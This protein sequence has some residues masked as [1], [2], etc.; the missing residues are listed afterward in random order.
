KRERIAEREA[1]R[2]ILLTPTV[3]GIVSRQLHE[4]RWTRRVIGHDGHSAQ[5]RGSLG[6]I[7]LRKDVCG[8]AVPELDLDRWQAR[9]VQGS[10]ADRR[11]PANES[12]KLARESRKLDWR[13]CLVGQRRPPG[14]QIR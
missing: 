5:D 8:H 13:G 11:R 3:P 7:R 12:P 4:R 10:P 1:V 2:T 9:R 14:S 6:R